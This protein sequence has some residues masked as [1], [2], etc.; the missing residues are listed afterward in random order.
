MPIAASGSKTEKWEHNRIAKEL[1][2]VLLWAKRH[3]IP[4][5]RLIAEEFGVDRR[6]G[7]ATEFLHDTV[8]FLN[9]EQI[10][11]AFYSFRSSNWDGMDYE[12]GTEKLKW[13]YWKKIE[14]GVAHG[15]AIQRKDTLIWSVLK[16]QF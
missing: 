16:D 9:Q 13:A 14:E 1:K 12:L 15:A 3:N 10:H 8:E 7:G 2:P 4:S 5:S 6:V 11:W